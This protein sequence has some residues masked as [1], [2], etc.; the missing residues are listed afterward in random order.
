MSAEAAFAGFA[1]KPLDT[2][3]GVFSPVVANFLV[4]PLFIGVVVMI[5]VRVWAE[6]R[7][8]RFGFVF[9]CF[10]VWSI[11]SKRPDTISKAQPKF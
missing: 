8:P 7:D 10:H 4:W 2:V 3:W 1:C 9:I 5:A 11:A 6:G